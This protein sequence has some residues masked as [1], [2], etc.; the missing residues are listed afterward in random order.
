[1]MQKVLVLVDEANVDCA[2]R[3]MGRR[4]D[5]KLL[6]SFLADPEEGRQLLEMVIY[7]GLPPNMSE[8]SELEEH[9]H[10]Q[11]AWMRREGFMVEV[12][13][14]TPRG[15]DGGFKANVDIRMAID[16]VVLAGQMNPDIIVLVTGDGDFAYLATTLRRKGFRVEAAGLEASM[17]GSLHKACNAVIDLNPLLNTFAA[18]G[19]EGGAPVG[20]GSTL[21]AR[22]P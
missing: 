3:G 6:R 19:R 4:T 17:S 11:I 20:D 16:A 21:F 8:F 14:G 22:K 9:R 1:M 15:N 2:V 18:N 5:W 12:T 10:R 13:T 7:A